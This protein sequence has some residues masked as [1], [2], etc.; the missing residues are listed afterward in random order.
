[1]EGAALLARLRERSEILSSLLSDYCPTT[2][3]E[4]EH[5]LWEAVVLLKTNNKSGCA[6][7]AGIAELRL[8]LMR[9]LNIR[10]TT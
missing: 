8:P 6:C 5:I 3:A 9:C 10:G 2:E 7:C 4:C 1:M